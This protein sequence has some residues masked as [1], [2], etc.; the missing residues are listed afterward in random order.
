MSNYDEF[1]ENISKFNERGVGFK[2][3]DLNDIADLTQNNLLS[4]MKNIN[5]Q[6]SDTEFLIATFNIYGQE[7]V[8]KLPENNAVESKGDKTS[9]L[10]PME[11][12]VKN[13]IDRNKFGLIFYILLKN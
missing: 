2:K 4:S 11:I 6:S 3:F 5:E 7:I 12:I 9:M 1:I 10:N 13:S 8:I